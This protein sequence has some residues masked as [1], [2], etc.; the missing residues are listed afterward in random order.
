VCICNERRLPKMKPFD[1]ITLD[2]PFR[3]PE[4]S[5][6]RS[7]L[8]SIAFREKMSL[9]ANVI[10]QLVEGTRSDIRQVINMLSTFKTT[11]STMSFDESK[12]LYVSSSPSTSWLKIK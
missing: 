11:A 4:V 9:P 12:D 1:N 3:R 8:A 2:L 10:D 6:I 7:R 5:A